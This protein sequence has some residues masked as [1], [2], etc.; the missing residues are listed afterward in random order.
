MSAWWRYELRGS[1]G[2]AVERVAPAAQHLALAAAPE[3]PAA[4]LLG[5]ASVLALG[6]QCVAA[7]PTTDPAYAVL[8]GALFLF[9]CTRAPPLLAS[10][11]RK[12]D[13]PP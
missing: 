4:G 2:L 5:E 13:G 3:G 8:S 10:V 12:L 1:A 7:T 9:F 6:D 11:P